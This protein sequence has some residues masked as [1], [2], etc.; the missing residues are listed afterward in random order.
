MENGPAPDWVDVFPIKY[1][2]IPGSYVSL[3]EGTIKQIPTARVSPRGVAKFW[4]KR[5]GGG[6]R[7]S[8]MP[9]S[10]GVRQ[11]ISRQRD[12]LHQ[13]QVSHQKTFHEILVV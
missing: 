5:P 2:D 11:E 6:A 8:L 3:P 7:T 13:T 4:S 12:F 1:G 9:G 10:Y